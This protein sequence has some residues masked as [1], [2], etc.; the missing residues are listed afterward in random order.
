MIVAQVP[1][2]EKSRQ[3]Y[4]RLRLALTEKARSQKGQYVV[5]RLMTVTT[6]V[7]VLAPTAAKAAQTN[8]RDI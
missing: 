8:I 4:S 5:R 1:V 2:Y 3:Y 7:N 6:I